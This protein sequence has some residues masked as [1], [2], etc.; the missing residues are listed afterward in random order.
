MKK[1]IVSLLLMMS[2]AL[3]FASA[4]GFNPNGSMKEKNIDKINPDLPLNSQVTT[5]SSESKTLTFSVGGGF[6]FGSVTGINLTGEMD[7]KKFV[8]TISLSVN[9]VLMDTGVIIGVGYKVLDVNGF[10]LVPS[11]AFGDVISQSYVPDYYGG[12]YSYNHHPV[13][14]LELDAA[15]KF[16]RHLKTGLGLAFD[17]IYFSFIGKI[18]AHYIF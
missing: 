1:I 7:I 14:G 15:Y 17:F 5:T 2:F 11:V 6:S 4:S 3:S 9:P 8:T 13:V 12:Y 16:N 18:G 10:E